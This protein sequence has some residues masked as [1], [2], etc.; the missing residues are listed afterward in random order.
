MCCAS[1]VQVFN[2]AGQRLFEKHDIA[3]VLLDAP[4]AVPLVKLPI[5]RLSK[6]NTFTVIGFGNLKEGG[7]EPQTL[8]QVGV[9]RQWVA[10]KLGE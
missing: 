6:G 2:K 1:P 9:T 5:K 10:A 8:M 3:V 4:V 7:R